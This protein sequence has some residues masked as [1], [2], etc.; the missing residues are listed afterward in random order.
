[1]S[2]ANYLLLLSQRKDLRPLKGKF[3]ELGGFYNGIGY[4]FP[5]QQEALLQQIVEHL[6]GIKIHKVPL[7]SDQTFESFRQAHNASYFR[8]KLIKVEGTL[9]SIQHALSLENLSEESLAY[10]EIHE[11]QKEH[12]S[13]LLHEREKLKDA[14]EWADGVEKALTI[15][16]SPNATI[17]FLNERGTNFLL[18]EAPSMPRLVNFLEGGESKPFIRKGIVGMLVGAGGVGKTHALAQL[19]IAISTGE[20]LARKIPVEK[21]GYVF[22]GLGENSDDDIH[23]LLRK[24]VKSLLGKKEMA[25]F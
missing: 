18:E 19:A 7:E 15:D 24:I 25:T 16:G 3:R 14:I 8:E 13:T 12:I 22:M 20:L 17:R 10:L 23:R 1:M 4:V 11:S 9:V 5:A 2:N 6:P 21:P